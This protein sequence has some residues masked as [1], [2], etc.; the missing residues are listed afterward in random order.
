MQSTPFLFFLSVIWFLSGTTGMA[1]AGPDRPRLVLQITV[2]QLRGDL[3]ERYSKGFGEGGFRYL[4][5]NG[6]VYTNAHHRHANTETI[7]GHTTLA[8]GADPA[9]HG[10]VANVWFDRKAEALR[11]NVQD[12]RFRILGAGGVDAD[13]EIDPTQKAATTDGRSPSVLRPRFSASP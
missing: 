6:V 3:I 12:E 10:M 13:T 11:Y 8:T 7:V 1:Q 5:D 9:V 4:L 2:D